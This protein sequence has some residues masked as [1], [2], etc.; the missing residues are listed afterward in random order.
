MDNIKQYP[1]CFVVIAIE[2]IYGPNFI[3]HK[4]NKVVIH[5]KEWKNWTSSN[6]FIKYGNNYL[7][8]QSLELLETYF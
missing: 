5:M 6:R 4:G 8:K 1:G 3:I 2:D 7:P